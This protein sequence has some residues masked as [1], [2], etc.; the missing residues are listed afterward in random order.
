[1]EKVVIYLHGFLSSPQ[2]QKAQQT[3]AFVKAHYPQLPIEIPKLA[4][5]PQAAIEGI[6]RVVQ[7]HPG[8]TCL[9]IGSSL[10]GFLATYM[11]QKYG[12]K[13]VIVNPAVRPFELLA[14]YLGAHINP[15]TRESFT[16]EAAHIHQLI[17]LDV[18]QVSHPQNIWVLLQT[19]DEILDYRQAVDKYQG[20]KMT[21]EEGGDHSFQHFERFLPDIF[22]FL[23]QD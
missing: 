18:Q 11:L 2:S 6:E 5:Y 7:S 22:R 13:A 8:K 14:D 23:L 15:Y 3:L 16:L 19:G 1:M 21:V 20:A 17:Q 9:F 10:G 4:N 12:G